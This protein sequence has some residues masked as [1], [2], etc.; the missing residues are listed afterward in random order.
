M[1][2]TSKCEND[3]EVSRT[4]EMDGLQI[5]NHPLRMTRTNKS[6]TFKDIFQLEEEHLKLKKNNFQRG[7]KTEGHRGYI[8]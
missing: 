6:M 1:G 5:S 3:E 7:K 4:L 8:R 2:V